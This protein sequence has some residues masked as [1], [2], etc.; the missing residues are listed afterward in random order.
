MD[1]HEKSIIAT[2]E[3]C[4]GTLT[5][6]EKTV[7]DYFLSSEKKEDLSVPYITG[8][9]HVSPAS[10]VRFSKK[11][12]LSGYREFVYRYQSGA[13][14]HV[15][16]MVEDAVMVLSTYQ[17]L[18]NRSYSLLDIRQVERVAALIA[19]K[20]RVYIYGVGNSGLAAR[21]FESRFIRVGVDA[22][23]VIDT[24]RMMMDNA[25]LDAG[26]LVIAVSVSGATKEVMNALKKAAQSGASTVL[27]TSQSQREWEQTFDEVMLVAV[28]KRLEYGDVISPQFPIL[29]LIDILYVYFIQRDKERMQ[30]LYG[31]SLN[32]ILDAHDKPKENGDFFRR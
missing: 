16:D 24:H 32:V 9:L 28:T 13:A 19:Q 8:R 31:I 14:P 10:L 22:T 4:Y 23:A 3:A 11:L 15:A 26:C 6:T 7:A 1:Y 27:I 20:R 29:V 12:G 5:E 2:L 17:E 30:E 18:L 25:G 21:E